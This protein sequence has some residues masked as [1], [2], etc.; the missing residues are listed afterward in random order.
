MVDDD[1]G[2][3]VLWGSSPSPISMKSGVGSRRLLRGLSSRQMLQM[4]SWPSQAPLQW[5]GLPEERWRGVF[6]RL[7]MDL[8]LW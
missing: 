1:L 2:H 6:E 4:K 8:L 3:T 7:L 5:T